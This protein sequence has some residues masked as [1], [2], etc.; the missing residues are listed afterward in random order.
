MPRRIGDSDISDRILTTILKEKVV[1]EK[2]LLKKVGSINYLN[3]HY[4]RLIRM[5]YPI[6]RRSLASEGCSVA[7]RA[8]VDH[9]LVIYY[10]E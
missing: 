8:R 9:R 6:R 10:M 2:E 4:Q 5:G 3:I 7:N 1:T